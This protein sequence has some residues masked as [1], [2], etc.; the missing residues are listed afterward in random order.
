[1]STMT[2]TIWAQNCG[3]R[4]V[5]GPFSDS[6]TLGFNNRDI[7]ADA[8]LCLL[9]HST[10]NIWVECGFSRVISNG[11]LEEFDPP[12]PRLQRSGVT[13]ITFRTSASSN[14]SVRSRWV[15]NVW[16]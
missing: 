11:Q 9:T 6:V 12:L 7:T 16:Q 15:I 4:I 3:F 5:N 13:S 8:A 1:M 14:C 2:G 10:A